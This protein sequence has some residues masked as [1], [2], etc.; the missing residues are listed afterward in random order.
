M[1]NICRNLCRRSFDINCG[2]CK[3][4]ICACNHSFMSLDR[5][6]NS[7]TASPLA[8]VTS[9]FERGDR[10]IFSSNVHNAHP[11]QMTLHRTRNEGITI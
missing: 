10:V 11:M 8:V 6:K 1:M 2:F 3:Q 7:A 4:Y 9:I 5:F